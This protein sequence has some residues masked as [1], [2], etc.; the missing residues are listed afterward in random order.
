MGG[1]WIMGRPYMLA[2]AG[3]KQGAGAYT[4]KLGNH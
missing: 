1:V 3:V 4:E 2:W